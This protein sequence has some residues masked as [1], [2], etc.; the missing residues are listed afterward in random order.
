MFVFAK[1]IGMTLRRPK[2]CQEQLRP[3]WYVS[4]HP[5]QFGLCRTEA[6]TE[7]SLGRCPHAGSTSMAKA[8]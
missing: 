6:A 7:L 2:S 4:S 1:K 3:P 8:R 5:V